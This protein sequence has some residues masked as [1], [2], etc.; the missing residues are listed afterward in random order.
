MKYINKILKNT[1]LFI[2]I[3]LII[4][5]LYLKLIKHHKKKLLFLQSNRMINEYEKYNINYR[6]VN[7]K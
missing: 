4:Y 5:Y 7:N 3:L 6:Y 1:F 2:L